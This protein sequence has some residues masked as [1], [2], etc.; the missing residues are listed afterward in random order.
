MSQPRRSY[1]RRRRRPSLCDGSAPNIIIQQQQQQQQPVV[2]FGALS[3]IYVNNP[4]TMSKCYKKDLQNCLADN[5]CRWMRINDANGKTLR[6]GCTSRPYPCTFFNNDEQFCKNAGCEYDRT[7]RSCRESK[8]QPNFQYQDNK[9]PFGIRIRD[10]DFKD[11]YW[12]AQTLDDMEKFKEDWKRNYSH[13]DPNV[14]IQHINHI[15][16]SEG[17]GTLNNDNTIP[18]TTND[19]GD[20]EESNDHTTNNANPYYYYYGNNKRLVNFQ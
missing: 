16:S 6:E 13:I 12:N 2:N 1:P 18:F 19:D 14:F 3:D 4:R 10:N 17:I 20:D 9:Q 5:T 11:A 8:D 7:N 15:G